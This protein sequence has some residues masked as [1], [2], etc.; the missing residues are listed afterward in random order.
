M[1]FSLKSWDCRFAEQIID[2]MAEGVFALD[3]R[4]RI[5]SWNRSMECITGRTAREVIGK[6]CS[7]LGFNRCFQES[8]PG[9]FKKCAL[10][11][12]GTVERKECLLRHREGYD[13]PVIK[14]A[15]LVK[16]EDGETIGIVETLTDITDLQTARKNIE[17]VRRRLGERYRF[18]NIVGKSA[19][20]QQ[21]FE[22]IRAAAASHA[23]VL[24][25]GESGSGKELVAGA[26]H[27]NSSRAGGPM[28][29]VNCSALSESLL[30]SELFGHVKGA[31]TGAVRDRSGR[32]EDADGGTIFLDE[33]SEISP[34]IQIKLLRVL[35]QREIERVGESAT[36]KI[37]IRVI[38]ATNQDLYQLV[39]EGRFRED[40]Y[41]RLKVFPIC[42]PP[43]TRRRED[44]PLLV[45]HFIQKQNKNTGKRIQDMTSE[46][47]RRIMD[48]PWPGNVRE[49]ENA[50]EHAFVLCRQNRIDVRDLPVEIRTTNRLPIHVRKSSGGYSPN[51][52]SPNLN[53]EVLM[54][55]LDQSQWNKAEVARQLSVSRTAVWK[56]MKKWNIPLKKPLPDPMNAGQGSV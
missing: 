20:M 22:K 28:V 54:N 23:T 30:E 37:N 17:E 41:Y 45:A 42:I 5:M 44:I 6:N 16:N 32:F 27:Y 19:I 2:A 18:G 4:G 56:Y 34:Y 11:K 25:Q 51:G 13:V 50:V 38:A 39:R 12:R 55:L 31:F 36:R 52:S 15:R 10:H 3:S 48:Y 47:M 24:I 1:K 43:L 8:C 33:I 29:T 21:V 53:R 14:N 40:F 26:I 7:I 35:Q 9:D 46:A 49:L